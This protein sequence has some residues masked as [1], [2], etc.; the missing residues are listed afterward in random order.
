MWYQEIFHDGLINPIWYCRCLWILL[1]TRLQIEVKYNEIWHKNS[2]VY[3]FGT[4]EFLTWRRHQLR[5][6]Y[7]YIS[8]ATQP[9]LKRRRTMARTTLF[10]ACSANRQNYWRG[11]AIGTACKIGCLAWRD[12]WSTHRAPPCII[13]IARPLCKCKYM[14]HGCNASCNCEPICVIRTCHAWCLG[15]DRNWSPTPQSSQS[16]PN[17]TPY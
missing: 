6:S 2:I 12:V 16:Q 4:T 15:E 8:S 7:R 14:D 11:R 5:L 13:L 3:I 10:L 1:Q 9:G 17:T